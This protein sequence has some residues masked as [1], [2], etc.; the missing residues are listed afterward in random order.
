MTEAII[1]DCEKK[2]A[3]LKLLADGGKDPA[4]CDEYIT[5]LKVILH[6]RLSCKLLNYLQYRLQLSRL[7]PKNL[8][9][10]VTS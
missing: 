2:L 6:Y 8:P 7:I 3:E 10:K 9:L 5:N 1:S 4:K